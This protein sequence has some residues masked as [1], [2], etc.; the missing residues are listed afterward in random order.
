LNRKNQVIINIDPN[1]IRAL[2][3]SVGVEKLQDCVPCSSASTDG[4][5]IRPVKGKLMQ[6]DKQ[7]TK[8]LLTEW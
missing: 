5:V 6:K 4:A 2:S 7:G 8:R 3:V 1:P